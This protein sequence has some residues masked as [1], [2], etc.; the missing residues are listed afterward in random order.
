MPVSELIIVAIPVT[1][2]GA[3]LAGAIKQCS[4]IAKI[5]DATAI[6][7]MSA[8]SLNA[9]LRII[10]HLEQFLGSVCFADK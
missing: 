3:M 10:Y 6:N 9:F 8:I 4:P 5:Q 1:P 2:P 7:K